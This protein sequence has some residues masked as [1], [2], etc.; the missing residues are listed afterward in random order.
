[1]QTKKLLPALFLAFAATFLITLALTNAVSLPDWG[2]SST[3]ARTMVIE[4]A[5][6]GPTNEPPA[7]PAVG[8]GNPL[9]SFQGRL[10]NPSTGLPVPNGNY[11]ITFR[12]FDA[13]TA[14]NSVWTETQPSVAVNGGLFNVQLGSVTALYSSV[15]DGAAR[16]LEVQVSPD[17]AV[18]PRFQFGYVP[19]AFQAEQAGTV[20][21]LGHSLTAVDSAGTTGQ[22][23]SI[24][25]GADG[26]PII[27][28]FD[29][30]SDDLKVAHCGNTACTAGNTVTNVDTVGT[31]GEYTS[32]AIGS[33]G[34][35]IISYKD[36]NSHD[37]KVTHCGNVACSTPCGVGGT[38]CP[39]I[40]GGN[41]RYS[42]ITVGSDGLPLIAY[43]DV[44]N[45]AL[46][47]AHCADVACAAST[48]VSVDNTEYLGQ[49]P[50]VTIGADHLPIISYQYDEDLGLR[51]AHCGDITC[52]TSCGIGGT[53]CTD[54][55]T[56]ILEPYTSITIGADLLPVITYYDDIPNNLKVL[57]CGNA[58][59]SAGNMVTAVTTSTFYS[60]L[61]I[62]KGP[63]GLP[64]ITYWD[65]DAGDLKILHCQDA[66]C[67]VSTSRTLDSGGDVGRYT[68]VSYGADGLPVVSY[69]D[70]TNSALKVVHCSN[71]YCIPYHRQR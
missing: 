45:T 46:K 69:Y 59:C 5:T 56:T 32:I 9:V 29:D 25:T 15:F 40:D 10:L 41:T 66:A 11:S 44:T 28:Y 14:G 30:T 31:V 3:Q 12:I 57:H 22:H 53:V 34:L 70:A 2:A 6:F 13:L 8:G 47:V 27:S 26:L 42:S 48:S 7:I 58:A 20:G 68:S 71:I 60:F 39:V 33:D 24:T 4:D 55:D 64:T 36:L 1:M 18:T 52:S 37:L 63:D 61:A 35:P 67:T 54:V 62:T 38:T 50:S 17:P 16:Y 49:Y 21:R 19:Y 23:T 43:Y 65:G 51:V